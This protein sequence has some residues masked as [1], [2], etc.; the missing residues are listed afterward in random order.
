VR[1]AEL[2]AAEAT[3]KMAL[4]QSDSSTGVS[5]SAAN[6]RPLAISPS[7]ATATGEAAK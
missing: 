1:Y 6:A 7:P 2:A 3:K 4:Q 5:T